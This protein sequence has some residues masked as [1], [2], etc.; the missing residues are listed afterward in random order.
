MEVNRSTYISLENTCIFS[1]CMLHSTIYYY[2][3]LIK[4]LNIKCCSVRRKQ[5]CSQ[6][7]HNDYV[8]PLQNTVVTQLFLF[9]HMSAKDM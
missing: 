5:R 9:L 7:L 1:L 4:G 8:M 2:N 6:Q 3:K